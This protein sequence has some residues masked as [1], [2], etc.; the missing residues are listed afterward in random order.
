ML[1]SL[2]LWLWLC[3]PLVPC[4]LA[5]LQPAESYQPR[6]VDRAAVHVLRHYV[7][8]SYNSM[9]IMKMARLERPHLELNLALGYLLQ[10]LG[11][12]M[13][14]QLLHA[15]PIEEPRDHILFLVDT[16]HSFRELRFSFA[17]SLF[18]REFNFLIV[19]SWRAETEKS[20]LSA[21][22]S[23]FKTCLSFHV[24]NAVVLVQPAWLAADVVH[25]YGFHL[26]AP[27]CNVS[28]TPMLLDR[29][30]RGKLLR[31]EPLF[32]RQLGTFFGCPLNISWYLLP[33][34]VM[35]VGDQH[36]PKQRME[37]WRLTGVD[38]ELIKMLAKIFHFRLHLL[39]PCEKKSVA[40]PL[41]SSTEDCLHQLA[42]HNSSVIIGAMSGS[43]VLRENFSTTSAYHQSALVFVVRV[44]QH[45]GAVNQLVQPFCATVWLALSVSCLALLLLQ[46]LWRRRSVRFDVVASGL[47]V[48]T[49]LLGNPL[50]AAALPR[51]GIVR[52]YLGAWL[53]L[54]LVQR[55]A[56][57]GKLYD[58]FRL[59]Y[60]PP[61][62]ERIGELLEQRYQF[63]THDYVDYFPTQRS[64]LRKT[65]LAQR[66]EELQAAEDGARLTTSALLGNLA[67][68]NYENWQSSR[69]THVKEHIYLYQLVMC[70][71][72]HSILK[73]AFDRKLKQLQSA[74][75]VGHINR[76]FERRLFH[77]PY[78]SHEASALRLE[79]FCGL[80]F[81]CYIMLLTALSVF[82]LELL[83]LR[84]VW[85]RR[86]FD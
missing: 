41:N 5:A 79:M 43:H 33:P 82:L 69:L 1:H 84:V 36:D 45:M 14:V 85:L 21:L 31:Q 38:G 11:E 70:L 63:L 9:G 7:N 6:E 86:Y 27:G 2:R 47:R 64:L 76:H 30:E 78:V 29:Y 53:L 55:A 60:Y 18:D 15:K 26:Y 83:S 13:A 49:T 35:F 3:L 50:D 12:Q 52:C 73:F 57:Q 25:L 66:F 10:Q 22:Y 40:L 58:A 8:P 62:P 37:T 28:F 24:L 68:Y 80:N 54:A 59:P 81:I 17:K 72:R 23:I 20:L 75:I 77:A 16:P 42:A 71:H 65:N 48:H 32:G 46:W 4:C 61:V 67:H 19:L 74:G 44:D 34:Y 51:A 56:Y 39:P